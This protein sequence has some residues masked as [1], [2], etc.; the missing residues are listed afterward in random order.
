MYQSVF[1]L[2]IYKYSHKLRRQYT[3]CSLFDLIDD[4]PILRLLFDN[5]NINIKKIKDYLVLCCVPRF[6]T[7]RDW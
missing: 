4:W 2:Q 5:L 6:L 7:D 1:R 3:V